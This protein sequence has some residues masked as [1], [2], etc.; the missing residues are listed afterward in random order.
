MT[1]NNIPKEIT[2][3]FLM[4]SFTFT[5][6]WNQAVKKGGNFNEFLVDYYIEE[7]AKKFPKVERVVPKIF[8][9]KGNVYA[10]C[11]L[12]LGI[13]TQKQAVYNDLQHF[14][15]EKLKDEF[16]VGKTDI[17]NPIEVGAF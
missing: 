10:L 6:V 1:Q 17:I 16:F 5:W 14:R 13:S 8:L 12:L 4:D 11:H 2:I 7:I 15:A 3:T 9:T